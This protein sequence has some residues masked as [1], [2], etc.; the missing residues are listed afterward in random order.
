M[1]RN[2][3]MCIG[4]IRICF[5]PV[6]KKMGNLKDCT[7]GTGGL[8]GKLRGGCYTRECDEGVS[9]SAKDS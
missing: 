4:E 7:V 5:E 3:I 1:S 2:K 9:V 6:Q 8:G